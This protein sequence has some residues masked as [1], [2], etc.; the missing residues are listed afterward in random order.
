MATEKD[1]VLVVGDPDY[2]IIFDGDK[3]MTILEAA[4]EIQVN[5]NSDFSKECISLHEF[6]NSWKYD[7]GLA[8]R[9]AKTTI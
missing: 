7:T 5:P 9:Y 2:D 4:Y 3:P 6:I 8:V 1:S